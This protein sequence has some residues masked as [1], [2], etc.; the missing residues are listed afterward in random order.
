MCLACIADRSPTNHGESASESDDSM[1]LCLKRMS[2]PALVSFNPLTEDIYE[3]N[4]LGNSGP[5]GFVPF[6]IFPT[7]MVLADVAGPDAT[8]RKP[9]SI[10]VS[11]TRLGSLR[12]PKA[13]LRIATR[14]RGAA[15]LRRWPWLCRLTFESPILGSPQALP[16]LGFTV[17]RSRPGSCGFVLGSSTSWP[18]CSVPLIRSR[19]CVINAAR[20]AWSAMAD[21]A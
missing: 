2:P 9:G 19:I 14:G 8:V 12:R 3:G 10:G 15:E 11:D 18:A 1:T 5:N 13:A 20:A 17:Q 7:A 21:G 4:F 16:W 6:R